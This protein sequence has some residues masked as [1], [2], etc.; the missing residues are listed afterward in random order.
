T[1]S[2]RRPC[3]LRLPLLGNPAASGERNSRRARR[4]SPRGLPV[5][6]APPYADER[7][8][9]STFLCHGAPA[10]PRRTRR[11]TA[12]RSVVNAPTTTAASTTT[13]RIDALCEPQPS[14]VVSRAGCPRAA[15]PQSPPDRRISNTGCGTLA[16][17]VF[18]G[19]RGAIRAPTPRELTM[20][21]KSPKKSTS[22]TAASKSLKEKR[23]DKK[24]KAASK[25]NG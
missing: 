9:V 22:K 10:I 1:S 3:T 2:R 20:A 23:A 14:A 15:R 12:R 5:S 13:S 6:I 17:R 21:D 19:R 11:R 8:S 7:S 4:Y 24:S 18:S 25:S 16:M